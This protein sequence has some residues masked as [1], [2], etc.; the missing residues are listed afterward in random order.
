MAAYTGTYN[1]FNSFKEYMADGTIDLDDTTAN[2]FMVLLL[3][4]T[5][6]PAA[7]NTILANIVANELSAAG[8]YARQDVANIT[9]TEAIAGTMEWDGDDVAFTASGADFDSA[10][11]WVLFD[12]E[13]VGTTDALIAWGLIDNADSDVLVTNGTTL[14]LQWHANGLFRLT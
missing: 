3:D 10:R 6:E 5:L 12:D 13:S 9:W 11:Y 8:T 2:R 14:T 1:F 4:N 7:T